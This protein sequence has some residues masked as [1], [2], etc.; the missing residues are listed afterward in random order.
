MGVGDV[1]RVKSTTRG[2]KSSARC[3]EGG[4]CADGAARII[5]L[6]QARSTRGKW[7]GLLPNFSVERGSST[8][9]LSKLSQNRPR[10]CLLAGLLVR[11]SILAAVLL[12]QAQELAHNSEILGGDLELGARHESAI[13]RW[14]CEANQK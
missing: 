3:E 1:I 2:H 13:V 11:K 9:K 4:R 12:G 6:D 8:L 5:H 14:L 7:C 10:P